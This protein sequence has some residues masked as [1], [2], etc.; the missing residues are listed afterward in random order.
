MAHI[1]QPPELEAADRAGDRST[2]HPAARG[3]DEHRC[4]PHPRHRNTCLQDWAR[5]KDWFGRWMPE[6]SD[7]PNVF[8]GTYPDDP[9]WS[10]AT[11]TIANRD[12]HRGRPMPDGLTLTSAGYAGTGS[13]R[14]ASADT[15]TT[16]WIPSRRLHDLLLPLTHATD[17]AWSDASGTAIHDPSA[18]A[19]GPATLV[20]RRDLVPR[21]TS[22]GL[23]LFWTVLIGNELNNTDP[24]SHL[25]SDYRWV[26]ASASYLF[27]DDTITLI[28][29]D[30]T[31]CVPGPEAERNLKW[32]PRNTDH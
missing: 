15:E 30:A 12:K 26:S 2:W 25:D 11:G 9:Q 5:G 8:L 3:M 13:S 23:T 27:S 28:S 24:L 7:I 10:A 14:D 18:T 4:V 22:A 21:L 19:D 1:G 31:R 16:G 29:A 32:T 20:T 6:P 17:F